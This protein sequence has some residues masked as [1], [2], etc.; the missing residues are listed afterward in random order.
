MACIV[1]M[2]FLLDI[3]PEILSSSAVYTETETETVMVMVTV[4]VTVKIP[5]LTSRRNLETSLSQAD[6]RDR[7]PRRMFQARSRY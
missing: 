4:T 7:V 6:Q 2:D 1:R 3:P 5:P